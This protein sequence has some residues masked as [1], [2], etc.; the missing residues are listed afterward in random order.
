MALAITAGVVGGCPS[1][2]STAMP[3]IT[4]LD[5]SGTT[6]AGT[7]PGSPAVA[8]AGST[9]R[10]VATDQGDATGGVSPTASEA[11]P[12]TEKDTVVIV[13]SGSTNAMGYR[14][15][16]PRSGQASYQCG[17][18]KGSVSVPANMV[19]KLYA[20]V[21]NASPLSGLSGRYCA[22]SVSFGTRT[23][24]QLGDDRS[25]DI[26]CPGSDA[27]HVLMEDVSAIVEQLHLGSRR[28]HRGRNP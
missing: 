20:D 11:Q 2:R 18:D 17:D 14:I 24:L 6:G 21:G 27:S 26:S 22:K 15:E 9:E 4:D 3:S 7:G 25:P 1:S 23:Y 10:N 19:A 5:R 28:R 12:V 8:N 13:N 16:V